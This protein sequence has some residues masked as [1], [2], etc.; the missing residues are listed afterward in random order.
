MAWITSNTDHSQTFGSPGAVPCPGAGE[1]LPGPKEP[2]PKGRLAKDLQKTSKN[3][4]V[5][6]DAIYHPYINH[7]STIYQPYI[8]HILTIY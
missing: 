2:S 3:L 7:I 6:H 1:L 5:L 8:N 4:K